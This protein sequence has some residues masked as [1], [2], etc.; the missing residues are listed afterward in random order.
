RH[1][2]GAG[3]S[4]V[5]FLVL[6]LTVLS[7]HEDDECRGTTSFA[8][9][10]FDTPG[11]AGLLNQRVRHSLQAMTG[12]PVRF[13]WARDPRRLSSAKRVSKPAGTTLAFLPKAPR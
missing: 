3:R 13:Y 2:K 4:S 10:G 6:D 12:Q 11:L 8:S 1:P 7:Q 5:S 9:R